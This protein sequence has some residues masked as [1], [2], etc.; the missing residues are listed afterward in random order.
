MSS[1]LPHGWGGF[2]NSLGNCP[3]GG[4]RETHHMAEPGADPGRTRQG[5]GMGTVSGQ[6]P[7]RGLALVASEAHVCA[8]WLVKRSEEE[9]QEA[10]Q[11]GAAE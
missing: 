2:W 4:G 8:A 9:R 11:D 6:Q 7:V 1:T 10:V 5:V 3:R